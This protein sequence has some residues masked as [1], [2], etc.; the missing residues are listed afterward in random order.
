MVREEFERQN[1]GFAAEKKIIHALKRTHFAAV[2]G[3]FRIKT[4][5][6]IVWIK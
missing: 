4:S 6:T 2:G 5:R 3:V 1:G